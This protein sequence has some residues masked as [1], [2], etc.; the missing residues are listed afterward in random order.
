MA[1]DDE[2][3][4]AR[5]V[6]GVLVIVFRQSQIL[7]AFTIERMAARLRELIEPETR[8]RV[9]CDF[10]RVSYLSSSAL[11]MLIGLQRRVVQAGGQ[12]KLAGIRDEIMEV[13]QITKLD[14]VLD[15]FRDTEAALE[16]FRNKL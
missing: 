16:A 1:T 7:D 5:E 2:F 9:V 11:G 15:I 6:E 4:A 10:S 12:L 14:T 8:P 3:F 13:F